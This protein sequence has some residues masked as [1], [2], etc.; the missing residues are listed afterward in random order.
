MPAMIMGKEST[1]KGY[2]NAYNSDGFTLQEFYRQ[3]VLGSGENKLIVNYDTILT[4]YMYELK[5]LKERYELSNEDYIRYRFNPKLL[6]YDLY[7]TTELWALLLDINEISSVTEFDLQSVYVF[8]TSIVDR[9]ERILNLEKESKEYNEE[10]I[11]R[12]LLD[13]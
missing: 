6:S 11:S 12:A 9:L 10:A 13:G 7:G 3:E 4:K 8:P 5:D 2:I 1:V